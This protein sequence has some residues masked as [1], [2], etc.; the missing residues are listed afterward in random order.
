MDF[1]NISKKLLG[2]ATRVQSHRVDIIFDRDTSP[3][4]HNYENSQRQHIL[5]LDYVIS[6]PDQVRPA[7]F[8]KE[9]KNAKFRESFVNF[10][11]NHWTNAEMAPFI[12][13]R[14]MNV[15]LKECYSFIIA[16]ERIVRTV[17]EELWRA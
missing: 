8:T 11:M 9:L 4:I 17:N 10:L 16:N 15:S 7:D 12:G 14:I 1:G 13:N 6:G 5:N 2:M 3:S